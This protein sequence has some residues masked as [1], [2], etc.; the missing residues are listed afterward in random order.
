MRLTYKEAFVRLANKKRDG[1]LD[2]VDKFKVIRTLRNYFGLYG[3]TGEVLMIDGESCRMPDI[4]IKNRPPIVIELDGGIHGMGDQISKRDK[5]VVRD[6]DYEDLGIKL[7]I[8]NK[9]LTD[10]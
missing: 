6:K 10:N 8:I 5:D 7:V 3:L 1:E 9:E 2:M 4:F